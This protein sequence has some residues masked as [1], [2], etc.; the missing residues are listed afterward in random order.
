MQS[1][2]GLGDDARRIEL[3]RDG[4]D[5]LT[6]KAAARE[7]GTQLT[8]P[9]ALVGALALDPPA[10]ARAAVPVGIVVRAHDSQILQA[11]ARQAQQQPIGGG[12]VLGQIGRQIQRRE[13]VGDRAIRSL[14]PAGVIENRTADCRKAVSQLARQDSPAMRELLPAPAVDRKSKQVRLILLA[15]ADARIAAGVRRRWADARSEPF[16]GL[17]AGIPPAFIRVAERPAAV[18]MPPDWR[19]RI[20]KRLR[21]DV[22]DEPGAGLGELAPVA[23]G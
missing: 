17:V 2:D 6:G 13:R 14:G 20:W 19:V 9:G 23:L 12:V 11:A 22:A 10:K 7:P 5:F 16:L 8:P 1:N 4:H 21:A 18:D 15:G 3:I